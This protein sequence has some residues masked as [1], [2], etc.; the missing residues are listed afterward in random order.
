MWPANAASE[1]ACG[2][3]QDE[4]HDE[5]YQVSPR[6]SPPSCPDIHGDLRKVRVPMLI[7]HGHA[8][9][10]VPFE[11]R[12]KGSQVVRVEGGPHEL[13]VTHAAQV[14]AALLDV[15]RN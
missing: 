12:G 5:R 9:A 2:V 8:G 6:S 14:N 15:L 3:L 4:C 11:V 7:I 10:I 1:E 13:N